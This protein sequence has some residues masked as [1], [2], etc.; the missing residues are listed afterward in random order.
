M[1]K[2]SSVLCICKES[3]DQEVYQEGL[4]CGDFKT[5][6]FKQKEYSVIRFKYGK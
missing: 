4:V 6:G 1:C 3:C 2:E 5:Y